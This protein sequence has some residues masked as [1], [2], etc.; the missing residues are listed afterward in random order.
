MPSHEA[1]ELPSRDF[2]HYLLVLFRR[3]GGRSETIAERSHRHK[4]CKRRGRSNRYDFGGPDRHSRSEPHRIGWTQQI[5]EVSAQR[6]KR[7]WARIF[8]DPRALG[9]ARTPR[10]WRL[11]SRRAGRYAAAAD[12][13]RRHRCARY[14]QRAESRS[15]LEKRNRGWTIAWAT[16]FYFGTDAGWPEAALSE[17][18]RDCHTGGRTARG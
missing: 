13:Q 5:G 1:W 2:S 7:E 16:D 18:H 10:V 3:A 9:Y 6:A 12:R 14:G 15:G 11:V 4:Q 8:F 17:F